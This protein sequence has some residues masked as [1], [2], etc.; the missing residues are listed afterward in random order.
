[1]Y[2]HVSSPNGMNCDSQAEFAERES[3][4]QSERLQLSEALSAQQRQLTLQ[5]G[6]CMHHLMLTPC[7]KLYARM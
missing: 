6:T 5:Q 2:T 3:Q 4:L 1:M 7:G